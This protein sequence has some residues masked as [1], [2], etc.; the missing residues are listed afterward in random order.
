MYI[1]EFDVTDS[2]GIDCILNLLL[3][4]HCLRSERMR[5]G[6]MRM[7][8]R[9]HSLLE[10]PFAGEQADILSSSSLRCVPGLRSFHQRLEL[11]TQA[12]SIATPYIYSG[13]PY[14]VKHL[15]QQQWPQ[16]SP[17]QALSDRVP[18]CLSN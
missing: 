12:F 1:L 15:D 11:S 8:K 17:R 16:L 14:P 2:F 18:A 7:I 6:S 13:K 3:P 4:G 10:T 9:Q 5:F